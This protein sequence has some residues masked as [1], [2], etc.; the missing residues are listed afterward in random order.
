LNNANTEPQT[1]IYPTILTANGCTNLDT[2]RVRVN[3]TLILSSNKNL[4]QICS[5][6]TVR[7]T[8]TS[9]TNNVSF[10]WTRP[11]VSGILP[12]EARGL[13]TI[14]AQRRLLFVGMT[15]ALKELHMVSTVEW[16]GKDLMSNNAD[17]GEFKFDKYKRKYSGKTSKFVEEI[18]A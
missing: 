2:F 12:N 16:Q 15:R 5:G 6:D 10:S 17:M 3:P 7:T 11:L 18:K 4:P 1:V 13:D 14:E 9:S 8:L